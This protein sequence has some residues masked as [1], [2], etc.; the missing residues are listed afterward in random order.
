MNK[1]TTIIL[2]VVALAVGGYLYNKKAEEAKTTSIELPGGAKVEI[3]K[4]E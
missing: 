4:G 3:K 1:N 2:L